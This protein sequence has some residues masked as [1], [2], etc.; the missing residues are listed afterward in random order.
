MR[1]SISI[2]HEG[3][4]RGKYLMDED[5][6]KNELEPQLI[7]SPIVGTYDQDAG[8]FLGHEGISAPAFGFIS[9]TPNLRYETRGG[10]K[11]LTAD[12]VLFDRYK[13]AE[14][15]P[16]KSVSIEFEPTSIEVQDAIVDGTPVKSITK[17]ILQGVCILGDALKP[18]F[19]EAAIYSEGD[20]TM[21]DQQTLAPQEPAAIIPEPVANQVPIEDA[22]PIA[23]V[24]E[25]I[26]PIAK[27]VTTAVAPPA[28]PPKVDDGGQAKMNADILAAARETEALQA[29]LKALE[30]QIISLETEK[31]QRELVE[32]QALLEN[33]PELTSEDY[34]PLDIPTM[35]FAELQNTLDAMA[36]RKI[37]EGKGQEPLVQAANYSFSNTSRKAPKTPLDEYSARF[38]PKMEA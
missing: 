8:D 37:K 6:L 13:E 14:S 27:P 22:E 32:K 38:T 11:Y 5:F 10:E 30:G 7:G 29:K 12:V 19:H 16:G 26:A 35:S 17:A 24:A 9:E 20:P 2:C 4:T 25:P 15:I 36:Y 21:A 18:V 28:A 3:V 31:T 23:P 33:Y 34:K 1:K